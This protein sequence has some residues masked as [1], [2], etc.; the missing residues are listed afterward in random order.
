MNC[1]SLL[2]TTSMEKYDNIFIPGSWYKIYNL[3]SSFTQ[4]FSSSNM[5]LRLHILYWIGDQETLNHFLWCW[6]SVYDNVFYIS[7]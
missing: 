1:G 3:D 2:K 4:M 7:S 6:W 5:T